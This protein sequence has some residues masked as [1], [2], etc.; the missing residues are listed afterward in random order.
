[1]EDKKT[2]FRCS[3]T[4][5][6]EFMH[7]DLQK[8][9]YKCFNCGDRTEVI[10]ETRKKYLDMLPSEPITSEKEVDGALLSYNGKK[11]IMARGKLIPDFFYTVGNSRFSRPQFEEKL[12]KV[13]KEVRKGN[14]ITRETDKGY[15]YVYKTFKS[16][17][18]GFGVEKDEIL[19]T[20]KFLMRL[21]K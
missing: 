7:I 3:R 8:H 5:P 16:M 6:K 2:C 9:K 15:V 11:V 18:C 19:D 1:M 13:L 14:I 12:H 17:Q 21:Q 10:E 4:R 20:I